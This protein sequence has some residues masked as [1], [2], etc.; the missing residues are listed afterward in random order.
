MASINEDQN[1][2]LSRRFLKGIGRVTLT[3]GVV[4]AA[5]GAGAAGYGVLSARTSEAIGP[6][7]APLTTVA[8]QSLAIV[9]EVTVI[10]RFTGQFEPA[11][12]V[13]LGFEEGGTIAEVLV[14]EGDLVTRGTVIARLDT[15]LLEAERARLDA[16]RTALGAQ[17]ELARRTNDRQ[18][19]LLAEGHVTQQRVDET[20]LRLAEL[21]AAL[22]EADAGLAAID[23]RLS[24]AVARA[25]FDGRIGDR[26]LDAGA[27]AGPGAA[28]VTFLEDAPARFRVAIDPA[29]AETL[30]PG[31]QVQVVTGG[32]L[33]TAYLAD[34]SP[35]LDAATRSRVA[36]FDLAP[37]AVAPPARATG[38]VLLSDTRPANGAW[39][40]VSSLW[41]G[42]R[43]SWTILTAEPGEGGAATIATEAVEVLQLD[44]DRAFVRGTFEDGAL[45]LAGGTHRV[46]PGEAVLLTEV[47]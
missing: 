2:S 4:A 45:Y 31:V 18:M 44:G 23:V 42:P 37:G 12:E 30:E 33:L 17:A 24:K 40:P 47:N 5:I 43:G 7:P 3:V 35:E 20:S 39:V 38:E 28:V 46:V 26:L 10:R 29:L 6:E 25:P 36:F 22:V 8:A 13:A 15:R 21:E 34:L 1:L 11:Q 32:E 27:V 19:T 14:R 41:Q 9:D 16:S